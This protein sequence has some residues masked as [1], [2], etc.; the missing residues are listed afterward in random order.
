MTWDEIKELGPLYA[1][2]A[3]DENTARA[4]EDY[5]QRATPEQQREITE[6]LEVAALIPLALPS[7]PPP[8]HAKDLLM[9]R[10]SATA[11]PAL[12]DEDGH[13]AQSQVAGSIDSSE[14]AAK[15]LPFAPVQRAGSNATRWLLI[16]AT[17]LLSLTSGYLLWQNMRLHGERND[18]ARELDKARN[19]VK[20]IVSPTTKVLAMAG[21][22]S[23]QAS[24]KLVWDTKQQTWVIYI[25]NLPEPPTDKDYQLWYLTSDAKISAAVFRPDPDGQSKLVL[26]LPPEVV[27]N[28]AAAAVTL[29]PKGG[30]QQPTG[31]IFLKGAIL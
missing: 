18:L 12:I 24:A 28:L 5:L 25:Y 21:E 22:A 9:S 8:E 11:I 16:A 20:E 4:V 17:V 6:W 3:L 31:N 2:G 26:S 1:V 13:Q 29:E 7:I 23:P 27:K 14:S 30:S 15:V 10:I 19:E